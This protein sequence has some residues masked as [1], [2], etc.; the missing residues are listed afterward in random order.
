MSKEQLQLKGCIDEKNRET[1]SRQK[2]I[3]L[4]GPPV[5]FYYILTIAFD[6]TSALARREKRKW[7]LGRIYI[8]VVILVRIRTHRRSVKIWSTM[9]RLYLKKREPLM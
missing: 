7:A 3:G 1:N 2:E 8:F 5:Q 4:S 6:A 9:H